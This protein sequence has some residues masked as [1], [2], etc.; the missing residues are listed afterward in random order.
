MITQFSVGT[1]RTINLG[2]FES[3]RIEASITIDCEPGD[4]EA[5][6]TS[7]Q[8]QLRLLLED[9]YRAQHEDRKKKTA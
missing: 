2:N 7:A 3:L 1:S 6:K 4:F 8:V 5:A 9:T